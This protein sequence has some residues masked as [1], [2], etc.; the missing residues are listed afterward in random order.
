LG[1]T[2]INLVNRLRRRHR[3]DDVSGIAGDDPLTM[4]LLDCVNESARDVLSERMWPWNVRSDGVLVTSASR[5]GTDASVI[6]GQVAFGVT[7]FA[8]T[9][10]EVSAD[11]QARIVITDDATYPGTSF[12]ITAA[13]KTG[14]Q[15][16]GT[17]ETA[18]PGTTN[19]GAADYRT[20][21]A[22]Y[23]LPDTVQKVLSVR[24][25]ETPMRLIEVPPH[26]T[27]DEVVPRPHDVVSAD[28]E[29]VAIGGM[30][31]PTTTSAVLAPKLRLILWPVPSTALVLHYSYYARPAAMAA[32][33][34]RL[35]IPDEVLDVV[36]DH[37]FARSNMT[38]VGNDA[39]MGRAG[40]VEAMGSA[41]RKHV[42]STV[43]PSRPRSLSSHDRT[44][45]PGGFGVTKYRDVSGL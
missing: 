20:F 10:A 28:P 7:S 35:E 4:A 12:R 39:S 41:M 8:G 42:A 36:L 43:D 30:M 19:G 2:A 13:A 25:Q 38:A 15:L 32:A 5:T 34:D 45:R 21:V 3:I 9:E 31:T 44:V 1:D 33:T 26:A 17:L 16:L 29:F 24:H 6:N 18:W 14:S 11:R 23:A 37:A 27:F 40:M 22:E